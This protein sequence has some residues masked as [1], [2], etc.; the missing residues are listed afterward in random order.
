[1]NSVALLWGDKI[2]LVNLVWL[3]IVSQKHEKLAKKNQKSLNM[4]EQVNTVWIKNIFNIL[5]LNYYD[6]HLLIIKMAHRKSMFQVY[7]SLWIVA[8][9]STLDIL[10][11][12]FHKLIPNS[13]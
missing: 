6:W 12:I 8:S 4:C 10:R 5:L 11:S 7:L 9:S 2:K 13:C 1:M 3:I